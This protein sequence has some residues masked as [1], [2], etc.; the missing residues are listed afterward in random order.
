MLITFNCADD[1]DWRSLMEVDGITEDV[2]KELHTKGIEDLGILANLKEE[3]L[4]IEG[5]EV[6][7][8]QDW[9]TD[10]RRII[11]SISTN[12]ITFLEGMNPAINE[13]LTGRGIH[14]INQLLGLTEIP[15]GINNREWDIIIT[16]AKRIMEE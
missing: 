11:N 7:Q 1:S 13:I 6:T 4:N 9:R 2:A 16:D 12:S 10:S 8:I 3:N 5:F 15:E 14:L